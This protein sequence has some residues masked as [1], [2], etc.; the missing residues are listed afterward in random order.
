VYSHSHAQRLRLYLSPGV[1]IQCLLGSQG[2]AKGTCCGLKNS[3]TTVAG[4]LD[5]ASKVGF[6]ALPQNGVVASE[7]RLHRLR[8]GFPQTGTTLDVGEQKGE[9][10][11]WNDLGQ[12]L[13]LRNDKSNDHPGF[14]QIICRIFIYIPYLIISDLNRN[15][16][17]SYIAFIPA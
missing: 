16:A 12:D 13:E 2:C 17:A 3:M 1:G 11:G 5:H 6:D 10:A 15:R 8:I 14:F 4:G 9:S 7:G